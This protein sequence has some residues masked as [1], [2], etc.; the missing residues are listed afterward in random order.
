MHT[1]IDFNKR[2]DIANNVWT[3]YLFI[4]LTWWR[5]QMQTF[6]ALLAICAGNS[7]VPVNSPHKGPWRGALMFSLICVWINGWV[8]NCE[9]GDLRGYR[10]HYDLTVMICNRITRGLAHKQ[11]VISYQNDDHCVAH[12]LFSCSGH[13]VTTAWPLYFQIGYGCGGM[14]KLISNLLDTDFIHNQPCHKTF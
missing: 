8:N 4:C 10:A 12:S 13:D 6:S 9:P 5:H 3:G 7:P 11:L 2:V 14:S 1:C